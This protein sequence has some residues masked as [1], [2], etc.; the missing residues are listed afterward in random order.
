MVAQL[1]AGITPSPHGARLAQPRG[2]RRRAQS[3]QRSVFPIWV[4]GG[5]RLA[6]A[7]ET[8]LL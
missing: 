5:G 1:L 3:N 2:P 8:Q 4:V 6:E 7:S